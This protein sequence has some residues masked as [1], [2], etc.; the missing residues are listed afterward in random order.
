MSE[1][2]DPVTIA[3]VRVTCPSRV[4]FDELE[5]V[6]IPESAAKKERPNKIFID[7]LRNGAGATTVA[8]YSEHAR[9]GAPVST[10]LHWDEVGGRMKPTSFHAGNVAKRM[11]GPAFGSVEGL[12]PHLPKAHRRHEM[13]TRDRP[14]IERNAHIPTPEPPQA[15]QPGEPPPTPPFNPRP[16]D[17]PKPPKQVPPISDPPPDE[18]PNPRRY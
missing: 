15:P 17:D 11:Q 18:R 14:M 3:G 9:K 7:Y 2:G 5:R 12:P 1:V 8:A 6:P 13:Q 16:I 4:L 10:P